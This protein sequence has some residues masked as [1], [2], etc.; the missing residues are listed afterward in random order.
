MCEVVTASNVGGGDSLQMGG[1]KARRVGA[2]FHLDELGRMK[3]SQRIVRIG[4][5]VPMPPP[6]GTKTDKQRAKQKA[7]K[8]A[9]KK[10]RRKK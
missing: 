8:Q 6:P 5:P 3:E 7:D 9:R 4:K 2:H 10:Q 1:A